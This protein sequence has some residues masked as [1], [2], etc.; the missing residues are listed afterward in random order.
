[1]ME[2]QVDCPLECARARNTDDSDSEVRDSE[3]QREMVDPPWERFLAFVF[4]QGIVVKRRGANICNLLPIAEKRTTTLT[5]AF[6][7]LSMEC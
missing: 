3:L 6:G 5:V 1:M 4:L 7:R 2:S